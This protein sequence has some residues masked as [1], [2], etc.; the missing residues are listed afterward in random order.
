[1]NT[2][3][4]NKDTA[5]DANNVLAAGDL[6]LT[7]WYWWGKIKEVKEIKHGQGVTVERINDKEVFSISTDDI[8]NISHA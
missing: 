3:K 5:T 7:K 1:M 4:I 6:V 8:I 2:E